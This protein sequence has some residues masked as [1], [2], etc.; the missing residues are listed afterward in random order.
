[1]TEIALRYLHEA[2]RAGTM[3]G[4]SEKLGIAV[5]SISRQVTQLEIE[6]GTALIERGRR[7]ICLTAAGELAIEHYQSHLAE[8]ESFLAKLADLRGVR[9]GTVVLSI[10]EGFFG[11]ALGDL[12]EAFQSAFPHVRIDIGSGSTDEIVQRVLLDEAHMGLVFGIPSEPKI[13]LRSS[14]L[15]P[16]MAMVAPSHP[17]AGH[18]GVDIGGLV[19]HALCLAPKTFRI[20]KMLAAAEAHQ[21]L[22]LDPAMTTVSIL[23]MR[24]AALSGRFATILPPVAALAELRGGQ[25]IGIPLIDEGLEAATIALV[26]RSGRQLDGAPLKMLTMLERALRGWG[27]EPITP[28]AGA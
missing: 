3:R 11:Q 5:S 19:Q 15:Q 25:L 7:T 13:R 10:G 17:L 2:V 4:A 22:F 20:R 6:Y 26:T 14:N 18:G 27:A 9:T 24:Q 23:M 21:H 28:D 1:M 8:R 16:L 12:I